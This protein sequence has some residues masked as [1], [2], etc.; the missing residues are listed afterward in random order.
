[1]RDWDEGDL[2]DRLPLLLAGRL[3]ADEA[4]A[5]R[6][7]ATDDPV[8]A[9]ELALLRALREAHG[10]APAVDVSAIVAALPAP[11][12][13]PRAGGVPVTALRVTRW[14]QAA[15]VAAVLSVGS[16]GGWIARDTAAVDR[17]AVSSVPAVAQELGLGAPLEELSDEQLEALAAEIGTLDGLPSELPD[18]G[19][20]HDALEVGA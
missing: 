11:A 1:M 18:A 9:E 17:G 5:V 7:H 12:R 16:F 3:A 4:A 8:L 14:A 10:A 15:A 13:Q 20:T 2:R 6:A 19:A